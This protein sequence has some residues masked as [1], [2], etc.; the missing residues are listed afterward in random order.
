MRKMLEFTIRHSLLIIILTIAMTTLMGFAASKIQMNPNIEAL[1]PEN[2]KLNALIEKYD[3]ENKEKNLFLLALEVKGELSIEALQT[4]EQVIS[5]INALTGGFSSSVFTAVT[6][7]KKGGRLAPIPLFPS[8]TAPQNEEDFNTYKENLKSDLFSKDIFFSDMGNKYNTLFFHPPMSESQIVLPYYE[9]V[10]KLDPYFKTYS[11]GTV[12]LTHNSGIYLSQDLFKLLILSLLAILILYYVGFR[13][14]RALILPMSIVVF[15]TIWALGLMGILGFEI[16]M[17]SIVIPP[18]VLTIGTSY[19]IHFLNQYYHDAQTDHKDNSWIVEASLHVNKT[20]I[21][22]AL[23]TVI[24]FM[25]LMFTSM[26]ASREF[27]LST[28]MGIIACAILS[29]TFLPAAL[30]RMKNPDVSQKKRIQHGKFT[31]FMGRVSDIVYKG[32]I[33]FAVLLLAITVLFSLTYPKITHQ[34]DYV[35]YFPKEDPVKQSLNFIM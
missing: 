33:I 9:I 19:A 23:T 1:M 21:M 20:I 26:N 22:A 13:S 7:Q 8:K 29:M 32:R 31:T 24:G 6:F 18:L 16:T 27:G 17:V 11:T 15:G 2:E 12:F 34:S 5:E 30:S 28:S 10:K 3:P 14:K 4:Y 35:S 25:S